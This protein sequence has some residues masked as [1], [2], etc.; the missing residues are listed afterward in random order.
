M[1][2]G[3]KLASMKSLVT[4]LGNNLSLVSEQSSVNLAQD[5]ENRQTEE[6]FGNIL[7]PQNNLTFSENDVIGKGSFSTVFKGKLLGMEVAIKAFKDVK[8]GS[9]TV[10]TQRFLKEGNLVMKLRHPHVAQLIAGCEDSKS[11]PL[12]IF[13]YLE[14]GS[15]NHYIHEVTR[16]PLDHTTLYSIS[17]DVAL[18]LNYLHS[19]SIAHLDVKSANVLL[20]AYLRAKLA[21][22]GLA[23]DITKMPAVTENARPDLRGTPAFMAPEVLQGKGFSTAADVYGF[24]MIL[25]EMASGSRPFFGFKLAEVCQAVCL[26]E[27]PLIPSQV[28]KGLRNLIER[29]WDQEKDL[30]PDLPEILSLLKDLS[31]PDNWTALLGDQSFDIS[32]LETS[33]D[34]QDEPRVFQSTL[35]RSNS[36][37]VP[38][39]PPPPPSEAFFTPPLLKSKPA[40]PKKPD[41]KGYSFTSDEIQ[42]QKSMLR[43]PDAR[44]VDRVSDDMAALRDA[45]RARR[46]FRSEDDGS[47]LGAGKDDPA[48]SSGSY[49]GWSTSDENSSSK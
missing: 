16:S 9:T 6:A 13:E 45:L 31:L 11:G 25:W 7:V 49:N 19:K 15:L 37:P 40:L 38:P 46:E 8:Q 28:T 44:R 34:G 22:L 35:L 17:R 47:D 14:G 20:D 48:E 43:K 39:T 30:R 12:L 2:S 18:A 3:Q 27:R 29:C 23:Q 41:P 26:A 32:S 36:A 21:D 42:K 33:D 4:E 5:L 10:T 1:I 24:G